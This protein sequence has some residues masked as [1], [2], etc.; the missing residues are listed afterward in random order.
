MKAKNCL[1]AILALLI[2]CNMASAQDIMGGHYKKA[3]I[4]GAHP[5]DPETTCGGTMLMLKEQGCEVVSVYLTRGER[6]I[7]GKTLEEAAAIREAEALKACEMMGVRAV[8]LT[9]VDGRTEINQE[10][11]REM[12]RLIE[13]EKPDL[14]ITHWPIDGHRDH[15]NC[16][17]LVFDAWKQTGRKAD[18]F[19][20]EAMTGH[21]TLNFIPNS[22]VDITPVRDLKVQVYL[23]HESQK[24]GGE[25]K[26]YH[27]AMETMRGCEFD[28]KYAEAFVKQFWNK[29][30]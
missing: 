24:L 29:N 22:Y 26:R 10:R 6:G 17:S 3:L 21:Q 5:D 4:I 11:Y 28:C 25:V 14:I 30:R 12:I 9:Q 2:C 23:C 18:L 13:E 8:F 19:Y 1:F 16:A 15:R 27:D 20:A 7:G